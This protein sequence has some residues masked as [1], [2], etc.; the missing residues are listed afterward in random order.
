M[1]KLDDF[2][3]F[4]VEHEASDLYLTVGAEPSIKCH[5]HVEAIHGVPAFEPKGVFPF[6]EPTL[7]EEQKQY[8]TTHHE[9]NYALS[10][11]D[12]GRFRIN[13]FH[14]RGETGAVIRHIK[15]Y[16]PHPDELLLPEVTK[17]LILEKSGLILFVGA[18]GTGKSTSLASLVEYRNS[19]QSGHIICIED[20][21]E[22]IHKHK[23]SIINQREV[24]LDTASYQDA[25]ENTLR[26]A[27][28]VIMIGEIRTRHE[29]QHALTFAETG[30]LCLST[31][32]AANAGEAIER[33]INFFPKDH[34]DQLLYDLSINLRAIISQRL[35]KTVVGDRIAAFE[36]LV[37]TPLIKDLIRAANVDHIKEC[38]NKSNVVGMQSFD[39]HLYQ[40]HMQG[41]ITLDEALRNANSKNNLRLRITLQQGDSFNSKLSF[42]KDPDEE[43]EA[44]NQFFRVPVNS[45][46][47]K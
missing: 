21:I 29:M 44:L 45:I 47:K 14:Q 46:K 39:Q 22:Y 3:A 12:V 15:T 10:V 42:A 11:S 35:V 23:R 40:L 30:H 37:N 13:L 43:K 38:I 20:P 8:F 32:H 17:Q 33:C 34:R 1:E 41:K 26:Q 31:L 28:D 2:L 16:I 24:G 4:M 5:G 9:M 19:S 7:S 36:V 25:L 18:T 6:F 27:P